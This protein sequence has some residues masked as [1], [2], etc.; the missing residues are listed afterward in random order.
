M[1]NPRALND[2]T[3]YKLSLLPFHIRFPIYQQLVRQMTRQDDLRS[4]R[5]HQVTPDAVN[6]IALRIGALAEEDV[7]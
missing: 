5:I 4:R 7:R 6:V 2:T 1:G 3:A